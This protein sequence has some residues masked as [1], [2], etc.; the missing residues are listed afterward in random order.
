MAKFVYESDYNNG[1]IFYGDLSFNIIDEGNGLVD[2]SPWFGTD[3]GLGYSLLLDYYPDLDVDCIC[4][5]DKGNIESAILEFI[6][7]NP[8]LRMFVEGETKVY[9][10]EM[11]W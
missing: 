10:C 5:V 7:V 2:L 9:Y 3:D 1:M 6:K 11:P 4:D 8:E